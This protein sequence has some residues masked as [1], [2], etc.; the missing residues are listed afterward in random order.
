M[1]SVA[2]ERDGGDAFSR[3]SG[4]PPAYFERSKA[5]YPRSDMSALRVFLALRTAARRVD[6]AV[7]NWLDRNDITLTK[8]DVLHLLASAEP[9]G[10]TVGQ[11]R[12]FLR[13]TQPN[14]TFVMHALER[15]K[16]VKRSADPADRRSSL[17]FVSKAGRARMEEVSADHLGA[18]GAALR[19]FDEAERDRFIAMLA[20]IVENFEAVEAAPPGDDPAV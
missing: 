5:H 13:M 9:G 3:I 15:D 7:G 17:F 10:M 16:L 18:I 19:A 11:L 1:T 20:T 8:L 4:M 6:N 2:R 14:V 12:D